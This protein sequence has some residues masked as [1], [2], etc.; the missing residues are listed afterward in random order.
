MAM[1]LNRFFQPAILPLLILPL[2]SCIAGG[3]GESK[4]E[5]RVNVGDTIPH[6]MAYGL[7][8]VW[9]SNDI[10]GCRTVI[11]LISTTC[12][13]CAR[14]LPKVEAVWK[15]LQLTPN[16]KMAVISRDDRGENAKQY[17]EDHHFSMPFYG[18]PDRKI[19][20]LFANS[21][22]PR[23]YL[24]NTQKKV[25]W[26]AVESFDVDAQGLIALVESLH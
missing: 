26:M 18:D 19:F 3:S 10:D 1:N 23:I 6:F 22:V 20:E 11:A 24:V 21:Y 13:D 9:D 17:W 4:V 7:D 15:A 2:I 14:E 12:P 25:E 8:S 16:F 5:N